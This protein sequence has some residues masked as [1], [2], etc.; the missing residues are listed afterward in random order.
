M[1]NK[2][3]IKKIFLGILFSIILLAPLGNGAAVFAQTTGFNPLEGGVADPV[4]PDFQDGGQYDPNTV[5]STPNQG[6][7]AGASDNKTNPKPGPQTQGCIRT[8]LG[9]MS[10]ININACVGQL[11]NLWMW[12]VAWSLFLAGLI[13]D[14]SLYF[15]IHLK[16]LMASVPTVRIGWTIFRDL[17]NIFFIF[18]LLWVSIGTILGIVGGKT[19]EI[20]VNLIVVALLINF[21][22]FIT[23]AVVDASN[24]VAIH[25]YNLIVPAPN[26]S[27]LNPF[28][29]GSFSGAFMQ[30]L[31]I[32]TIYDPS[33][34]GAG[35][36]GTG[37]G[38]AFDVLLKGAS[39]TA[40]DILKIIFMGVFG[41]ILMLTAAYVFVVAAVLFIIRIVVLMFLMMLSPLAF[42]CFVLPATEKYAEE[43]KE[44]LI[45]QS[46][47]APIYLALSFVVV[48]TIQTP[49]FQAILALNTG[50]GPGG[51]FTSAGGILINFLLLIG[52][53][54][55]CIFVAKKMEA[56][57][58]ELALGAGSKFITS[59]LQGKHL[60]APFSGAAYG[61]K[62]L[63][64]KLQKNS[65]TKSFGEKLYTG[66]MALDKT[67]ESMR[68]KIDMNELDKKFG[69]SGFGNTSL[70][71]LLREQTTGRITHAKFGGEESLH[72]KH[73]EDIKRQER[74]DE[75]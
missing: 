6:G 75:I 42:L 9:V 14:T 70:G 53:M 16:E 68:K 10:G 43:W 64:E 72:E 51:I 31:K 2:Q 32:Q 3:F 4:D 29:S 22:L 47:F 39:G 46:L 69:E 19:K 59:A 63:G 57:G 20:I 58:E 56:V 24:I 44:K 41:S 74:Q 54:V 61:G 8:T 23:Q 52:L 66:S 62:W 27:N 13:L 21:S 40:L 17:S 50:V 60:S 34:T 25:F 73:E 38:G 35:A 37:V 15:T 55:G 36:V 1:S 26:G 30:G 49:E 28:G 48:K 45:S 7:Q 18:I 5:P 71:S 11:L 65:F 33:G 67:T 12:L